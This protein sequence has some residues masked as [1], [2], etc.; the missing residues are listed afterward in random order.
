MKLRNHGLLASAATLALVGAAAPPARAQAPAPS[1]PPVVKGLRIDSVALCN[2]P[3]GK[4]CQPFSRKQFTDP[5]P[6]LDQSPQG[7]LQVQVGSEKVWVRTYAVETNVPFRINADCDA[8]VAAKQPRVGATRG[9][10]EE[11]R[12]GGSKK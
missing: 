11:C 1:P 6:V 9:I 2:E 8:V 12:P 5:W 4:K 3:N 10:G 7:F